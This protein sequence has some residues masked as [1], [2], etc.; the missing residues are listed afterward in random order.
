MASDPAG[1]A[2]RAF[3]RLDRYSTAWMAV[4]T[5]PLDPQWTNWPSTVSVASSASL[6]GDF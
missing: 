3:N 1:R 6:I 4:A 5:I 2:F